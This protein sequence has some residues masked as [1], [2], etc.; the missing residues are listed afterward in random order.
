M[1]QT[2]FFN[3]HAILRQQ[4]GSAWVCGV[5]LLSSLQQHHPR[6]PL[7]GHPSSAP[8][9]ETLHETKNPHPAHG[10]VD[11]DRMLEQCMELG[12]APTV[13]NEERRA[14]FRRE[15]VLRLGLFQ[16]PSPPSIHA[17]LDGRSRQINCPM[18]K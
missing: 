8:R 6:P 3:A 4:R 7:F 18:T 15:L 9:R 2:D 5:A 1:P 12:F 13:R 11:T 10:A 14:L 16:L 17:P